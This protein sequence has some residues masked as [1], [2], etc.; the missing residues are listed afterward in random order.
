[1][2]TVHRRTEGPWDVVQV[3]GVD[4]VMMLRRLADEIPADARYVKVGRMT[5]VEGGRP[6]A[7]VA[8]YLQ[9]VPASGGQS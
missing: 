8:R 5:E 3:G 7:M 2:I 4:P 9:A 1:M 6:R